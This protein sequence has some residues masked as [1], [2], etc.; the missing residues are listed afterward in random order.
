MLENTGYF[1]W[2]FRPYTALVQLF[3]FNK[4]NVMNYSEYYKDHPW[5]SLLS[6]ATNR[7]SATLT[8]SSPPQLCKN[9]DAYTLFTK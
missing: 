1:T 8:V 3:P 4:I 2:Q 5:V 9:T 6:G 7:V